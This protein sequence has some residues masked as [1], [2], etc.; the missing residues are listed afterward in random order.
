MEL[1]LTG[2]EE[3]ALHRAATALSRFDIAAP[4]FSNGRLTSISLCVGDEHRTL[5]LVNGEWTTL[6][7]I[8][9]DHG[10]A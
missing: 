2:R 3:C 4:M 9:G 10:E 7:E 1:K 5:Y 6:D 8:G